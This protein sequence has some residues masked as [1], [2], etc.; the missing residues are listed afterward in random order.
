MRA[1]VTALPQRPERERRGFGCC[2]G[3]A[4]LDQAVGEID[5][6]IVDGWIEKPDL[7][8]KSPSRSTMN[9]L[10][11]RALPVTPANVSLGAQTWGNC[12]NRGQA[13]KSSK[14][15]LEKAGVRPGLFSPQCSFIGR[16]LSAVATHHSFAG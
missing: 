4:R 16:I 2:G 8:L 12:R 7:L 15:A 6:R 3:E 9:L 14:A 10:N 13:D 5:V 11:K 1:S